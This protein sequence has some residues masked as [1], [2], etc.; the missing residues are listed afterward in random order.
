MI[1]SVRKRIPPPCSARCSSRLNASHRQTRSRCECLRGKSALAND[2]DRKDSSIDACE[3]MSLA[4]DPRGFQTGFSDGN[5]AR[6]VVWML[7]IAFDFRGPAFVAAHE[8]RCRRAKKRRSR[9]KEKRFARNVLFRLIDVRN[10]LLRRLKNATTQT[11]E[12]ERRAHHLDERAALDRIVPFFRL[13][14]KLTRHKLTKCGVS[15]SSSRLRQYFLPLRGPSAILQRQDV[16]AHQLEVDVTIVIAHS[17]NLN[18]DKWN[19]SRALAALNLV[20][21]FKLNPL[22][23]PLLSCFPAAIPC[24]KSFPPAARI[25]PARGDTPG[26]TPS[27]AIAA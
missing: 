8:N 1:D 15:A 22:P 17:T 2:Q 23:V 12:R 13:L 5:L 7:G 25:F 21:A 24:R 14:R 20:S 6:A 11:R 16:V 27:V 18:D 3:K 4:L 10:N 26:T 9:R 19:N